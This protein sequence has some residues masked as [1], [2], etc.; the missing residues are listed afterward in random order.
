METV[1]QCGQF[2]KRLSLHLAGDLLPPRRS[3]KSKYPHSSV[4]HQECRECE[5]KAST[6][7]QSL[8]LVRKGQKRPAWFL[9]FHSCMIFSAALG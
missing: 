3:R 4:I 2:Y 6:P 9:A 7:S 1:A 5:P 8:G